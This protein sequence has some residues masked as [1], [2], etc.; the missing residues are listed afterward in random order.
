MAFCGS[1]GEVQENTKKQQ[2]DG[3]CDKREGATIKEGAAWD[4]SEAVR[5]SMG[6]GGAGSKL[7]LGEKLFAQAM[8]CSERADIV[9][10]FSDGQR[11][12]R[13]HSC[14]LIA[15][16]EEYEG[17]FR[18][19]GVEKKEG[20]VQVPPGISVAS[21]R[22]FLEFLYLGRCGEACSAADGRELVGLSQMY[23]VAGLREW[24]LTDGIG[25]ENVCVAYEYGLQDKDNR[26]DDVISACL[27]HAKKGLGALSAE[28]LRGATAGVVKGLLGS[29]LGASGG[30]SRARVTEGLEFVQR[31]VKAN[32]GMS[33]NLKKEVDGIVN[34][35]DIGKMSRRYLAKVVQSSGLVS[36]RRFQQVM[37][38]WIPRFDR[39][40]DLGRTYGTEGRGPEQFR[41][42]WNV[43]VHGDGDNERIAGI[44]YD[45]GRVLMF[46]VD[47]GA[48]LGSAGR[49]GQDPGQF[50]MPAC[51]AFNSKGELFVTDFTL[52][53][54]QVFDQ[55]G[56]FLR[57]FGTRGSEPGMLD[58]PHGLAFTADDQLVVVD[59][60]NNRVQVF[61]EDGTF[62]RAIGSQGD[63]DGMLE[64]PVGVAVSPDGLLYVCDAGNQRV[65][66]F[67]IEGKFIKG[68]GAGEGK[69]A[70][71]FVRPVQVAVGAEG[72]VLVADAARD[73]VQVFRGDGSHVQTIGGT[74]LS[75]LGGMCVDREGRVFVVCR[76]KGMI[77][78][79][80]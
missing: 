49:K 61:R 11:P 43:A 6:K 48:C 56:A 70:G 34:M 76:A 69:G 63:S 45:M 24:L 14:V 74:L 60:R 62:V 65:Q 52:H 79:L 64:R 68:V 22:A 40:F 44:D 35:I 66:V 16:C 21:F 55:G 12:F 5:R 36:D 31:W 39:E 77:V 2:C 4:L 46:N 67:D 25:T 7:H 54:I 58:G 18:S 3:G 38:H 53:R 17:L 29:R 9:F 23:H 51:A 57:H 13:G 8:E 1:A 28:R 42:I 32:G 27:S 41:R 10:E 15:M 73:D 19:G 78:M 33:E 71:E 20:V 80:A 37:D 72:Q 59:N 75:H 50:D 30:V 26:S 47:S